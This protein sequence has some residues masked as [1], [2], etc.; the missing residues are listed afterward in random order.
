MLSQSNISVVD[1]L[2][3]FKK[4]NIPVCF[5]VPTETGLKKSIMDEIGGYDENFYFSQDY[6]F[7][8]DCYKAG[9]KVS[10]INKKL[11]LLNMENNLSN[12]FHQEQK[13]YSD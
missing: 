1:T 3:E 9:Y 5:L 11:Y 6:K 13:Y 10:I 2:R 7:F 4:V 8:S 12:K